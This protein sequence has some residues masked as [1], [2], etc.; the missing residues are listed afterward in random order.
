MPEAETSLRLA[1]FLL[2]QK[3]TDRV[4]VAIDGA[5]VK[6][7]DT[8]HFAIADF[9]QTAQCNCVMA[10]LDWRGV[11]SHSASGGTIL[12]HSRPGQG[13]VVATLRNGR[14]FRAESKKGPLGRSNSSEELPRLREAL[15]QLLTIEVVGPNDL[16]AVAVPCSPKF[17]E[18]AARWR[19]APLVQRVGIQ[20]LTVARDGHVDGLHLS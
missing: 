20:I 18:L 2:T 13:D 10:A 19:A 17:A 15:G 6:T 1:F 3:L 11:Y 9:L 7:R 5:Q 4:E 14:T 16:L 8:V 12:L